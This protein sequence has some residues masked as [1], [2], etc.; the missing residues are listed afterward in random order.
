MKATALSSVLFGRNRKMI[1]FD[2][3]RLN[4]GQYIG[5]YCAKSL[6]EMCLFNGVGK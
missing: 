3:R 1:M 4:R 2:F 6:Q 5:E